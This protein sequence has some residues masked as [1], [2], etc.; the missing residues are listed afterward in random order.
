MN[1]TPIEGLDE[2][3]VGAIRARACGPIRRS[4]VRCAILAKDGRRGMEQ[5]GHG[6]GCFLDSILRIEADGRR[7]IE[8]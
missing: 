1:L 2:Q 4:F 6:D 7:G 3:E 8:L 5:W